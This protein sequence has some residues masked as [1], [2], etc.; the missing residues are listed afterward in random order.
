MLHFLPVCP[1]SNSFQKIYQKE[2]I[3]VGILDQQLKYCLEK[4]KELS[5]TYI[6]KFRFDL[7]KKYSA[8]ILNNALKTVQFP[9]YDNFSNVKVTF[10]DLLNKIS[11]IIDNAALIK[12]IIMNTQN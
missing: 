7:Y 12:E 2:V 11:D 9:N 1:C 8:E 10:P 6:I 5:I 4:I 3:D